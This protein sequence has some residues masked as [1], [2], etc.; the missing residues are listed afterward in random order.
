[1]R[2][3][4]SGFLFL[5][6]FAVVPL[7]ISN[8]VE[9]VANNSDLEREFVLSQMTQIN[10]SERN[11][12]MMAYD[13]E[14]AMTIIFGGRDML[15]A[16]RVEKGDTWAY[17][18]NTDSYFDMSPVS[19]PPPRALGDMVYDSQSDVCV[20][21]GGLEDVMTT[22][23]NAETWLYDYNTNTWTNASPAVAPSARFV[24]RMAYDS[25]SDRTILFG[26]HDGNDLLDE[27]WAYD[28]ESNLWEEMSPASAPNAR[29]DHSMTYDWESDRVILF[30]GQ[31]SPS[32]QIQNNQTWAYDYNT[33]SWTNMNPTTAPSIR[34]LMTITYDNESD[35]VV[36]FGGYGPVAEGPIDGTWLYDFNSNT[37][38]QATPVTHP[39]ARFRHRAVYD[40][41]LDSVIIFGGTTGLWN[42]PDNDV[43]P[44]TTWM[45]DVNTDTWTMM[46]EIPPLPPTT[47]TTTNGPT[48]IINGPFPIELILIIAGGLVLV[49]IVVL[50]IRARR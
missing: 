21:F 48:T 23:P 18:A 30:G 22:V 39:S 27:T 44:D 16:E 37:W 35:S 47:T 12:V 8:F 9:P 15:P 26:G 2:I 28:V 1:R 25:E 38:T 5:L 32:N 24:N 40:S 31:N 11:E 49:V 6:L 4:V 20:M 41:Q 3:L 17:D 29:V 36:L 34:T 19:S 43:E 7:V 50:V 13:S 14:S 10:Q 46:G 45:Y 42:G 33:D